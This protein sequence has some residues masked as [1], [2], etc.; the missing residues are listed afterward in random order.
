MQRSPKISRSK[1]RRASRRTRR[2]KTSSFWHRMLLRTLTTKFF[3]KLMWESEISV[4]FLL[5]FS[6]WGT[7]LTWSDKRD[8][9]LKTT[10]NKLWSN[11]EVMKTWP[12]W[13]QSSTCQRWCSK[14]IKFLQIWKKCS[15]LSGHPA[16]SSNSVSSR[17]YLRCK[18]RI[19]RW[20]CAISKDRDPLC[21]RQSKIR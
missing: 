12:P 11:R 10:T 7:F 13:T 19:I 1:M 6:L 9:D 15:K 21:K 20:K 8:S 2:Q 4:K 16:K 3:W 5:N 18:F 14:T 17:S